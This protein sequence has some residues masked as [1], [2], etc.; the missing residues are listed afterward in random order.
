MRIIF[1]TDL[2]GDKQKYNELV[3]TAKN[4]SADMVINAGDMLPKQEDS[5]RQGNFIIGFL[6]THFKAFE[7]AGIYYLCYPGNDDLRIFDPLFDKTCS[8]FKF[9]KQIAQKRFELKGYEFIGMNWVVDYPFRLKDRCRVDDKDYTF[10]EQFGTALL[11]T[12][13][14]WHEIKNWFNYAKTLPSIEEELDALV[15]PKRMEKAV[16]VIHMPPAGIGLDVCLSGK[17]V[18]SNAVYRFIKKQQPKLSLHGHIHESPEVSKRWGVKI[19]KT[20]CI[21]PGQSEAL[22]YVLIDLKEMIFTRVSDSKASQI[23]CGCLESNS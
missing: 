2:H 13:N 9:I 17:T 12:K 20:C 5:F 15:K 6:T 3:R 18:G 1:V 14:G 11:S 19:G 22:T 4:L 16:Y 8:N 10:Q 7:Q 21:Q 23:S